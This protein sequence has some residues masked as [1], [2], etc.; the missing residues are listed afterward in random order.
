MEMIE[1][2][3]I[4]FRGDKSKAARA[5]GWNRP[6]FYRRLR[7]FGIPGDFGR[8]GIAPARPRS[9]ERES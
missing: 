4:R 8:L 7:Y 5:I 6:K 3:L 1:S 9:S 2:A